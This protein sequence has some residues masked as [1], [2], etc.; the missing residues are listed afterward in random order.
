MRRRTLA[1]LAVVGLVVT[2]GCLGALTGGGPTD[3][4]RLDEPPESAYSWDPD[5]DVRI[6]IT[7]RATFRAVYDASADGFGDQLN[8]SETS[9]FGTKSPLTISSLRYRYPNGTVI[10]G[11][12]I[13]SH[14]GDVF[15]ANNELVIEPP[16]AGGQVAFSG[17]STPKRFSLPVY[18]DGSYTVVL[19]ENRRTDVPLFGQIVPEPDE[20]RM[21]ENR[22]HIYWAELTAPSILVRYYIQR[23][24]QIFG[25]L[26]GGLAVVAVVGLFY[27]RRR[28]Q[29]LR[30]RRESM[31]LDVDVEDDSDEPPPGLR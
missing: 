1:L 13:E 19:P 5:T 8:L 10:N 20:K 23:D 11:S 2:S 6:T 24:I 21:V 25:A 14:G 3:P 26:A 15:T 29:E 16:V 27:Y 4:E 28:I 18:V 31:G 22:V 7:K 30:A 12:E 17:E 9:A